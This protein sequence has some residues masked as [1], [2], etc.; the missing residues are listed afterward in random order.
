MSSIKKAFEVFENNFQQASDLVGLYE[1][2]EKMVSEALDISDLLRMS[3]VLVVSALDYYV[4]EVVKYGMVEAYRGERPQTDKFAKFRIPLAKFLHTNVA[5]PVTVQE[6]LRDEIER[7]FGWK[8]FQRPDRISEAL[9]HVK[10]GGP[11]SEVATALS[12]QRDEII[13][14]LTSIVDR[15]N[16]IVHEADIDPISGRRRD[17]TKEEV[18]ESLEFVREVVKALNDYVNIA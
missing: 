10:E 15:R 2:L 13:A 1:G 17:I 4:H 9:K 14:R 18:R 8:S 6:W 11:W 7:Q 12:S 3:L 16:D 5:N